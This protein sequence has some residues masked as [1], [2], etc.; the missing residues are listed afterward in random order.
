MFEKFPNAVVNVQRIVALEIFDNPHEKKPA[1]YSVYAVVKVLRFLSAIDIAGDF[2]SEESARE[3]I[4]QTVQSYGLNLEIFPSGNA[5]DVKCIGACF[6]NKYHNGTE[7]VVADIGQYSGIK[8]A[9]GNN[10]S[11]FLNMLN[12]D[13]NAAL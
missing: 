4:K 7:E 11:A 5:I 12:G 10:F 6:V 2:T 9:D 1:T 3:Y 8:I 13:E